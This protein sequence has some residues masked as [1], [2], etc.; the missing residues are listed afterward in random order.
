MGAPHYKPSES[1]RDRLLC[2]TNSKYCRGCRCER[3]RDA[4]TDYVYLN[5]TGR[6][7]SDARP[8]RRRVQGL[9]RDRAND[10]SKR[11]ELFSIAAEIE[12]SAIRCQSFG[13]KGR[14]E[15]LFAVVVELR[16]IA[17]RS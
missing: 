17:A 15:R 13:D 3:C 12:N 16:Q 5:R 9:S 2:G 6:K 1:W 11:I 10:R 4:H 14:A 8:P 7:R